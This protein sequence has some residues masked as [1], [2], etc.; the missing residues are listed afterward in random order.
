MNVNK[1][2]KL[3]VSLNVKGAM[4]SKENVYYNVLQTQNLI[5]DHLFVL[6]MN[7]SQPIIL[8]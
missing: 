7:T 3:T 2:I 4:N 1:D 6:N 8:I 5:K